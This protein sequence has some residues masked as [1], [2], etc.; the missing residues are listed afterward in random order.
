M[1]AA[2]HLRLV[3]TD[4]EIVDGVPSYEE[5]HEQ[6][7]ALKAELAN[8]IRL[9]GKLRADLA[10]ERSEEPGAKD[11]QAVLGYWR[12]HCSPKSE[13]VPGGKRWE[14]VRARFK[15]KLGRTRTVKELCLAVDGALVDPWLNGTDSRSKGYLQAETIF[16][17][18]EQVEK[19]VWLALGFEQRHGFLPTTIPPELDGAA[20]RFYSMRC[21]CGHLR[22]DHIVL[23]RETGFMGCFRSGCECEDF[24]GSTALHERWLRERGVAV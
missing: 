22:I 11:I 20:L 12:E 23:E 14:K 10:R 3:N 2:S 1:E 6:N 19:L 21:E 4:G 5:L 17:D 13:I 8:Q 16:R 15:D 18:P 7:E 9:K 24:D